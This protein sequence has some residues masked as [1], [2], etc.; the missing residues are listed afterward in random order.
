MGG[1]KLVV[2]RISRIA[3]EGGHISYH[4]EIQTRDGSARECTFS[5]NM[6]VGPVV[7]ISTDADGESCSALIDEPRRF[8][9]FVNKEWVLR[10]LDEWQGG[11]W[12]PDDYGTYRQTG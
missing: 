3:G 10:F 12:Q 11:A 4:V 2:R 8:G 7:L 6:F 9:E 5:G 1:T